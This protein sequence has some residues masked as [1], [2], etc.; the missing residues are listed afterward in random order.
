MTA[1]SRQQHRANLK[2]QAIKVKDELLYAVPIK[3]YPGYMASTCGRIISFV[4]HYNGQGKRFRAEPR[5]LQP[6][7]R[8]SGY[9]KVTIT[10]KTGGKAQLAVHR[11]VALA[12]FERDSYD[13]KGLKRTHVN[14]I[15]GNPSDNRLS[16]LELV[17]PAENSEWSRILKQADEERKDAA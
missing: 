10:T 5:I 12:Y 6:Q 14:H 8:H 1:T 13:R 3:G 9:K 17:T 2:P 4:S 7:E 16:N 11:L 15:N